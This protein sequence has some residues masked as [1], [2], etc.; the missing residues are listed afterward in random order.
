[1]RAL[2]ALSASAALYRELR[3]ESSRVTDPEEPYQQ[4]SDDDQPSEHLLH[5]LWQRQDLLHQPLMSLGRASITVYRPGRWSRSSGP[6]FLD[7]KLRFGDNAIRVGAVE[8]HVWASDW[9]RHRHDLDPA[10][11]RVLLHVVWHNDLGTP[12]VVDASG[13]EIPQLVLA[14][15]LTTPLAELQRLLDDERLPTGQGPAMT[16]CQQA[17]LEMT[18]E[19]VGRLLEMA[20]EERWR[21][22]ANRFALRVERRGVE[23]ALYETLMEALGYQGNRMPFWQ[24]AKLAPVARL[25]ET[26]ASVQPT[27]MRVQAILYGVSGFL[28][29]W[30]IEPRRPAPGC[31]AYVATLATHW[32][33]MASLFPETLDERQWRT[34]GIRPANFPQRRI[35]AAGY[36]LADLTQHSLMEAWFAPIRAIDDRASRAQLRRCTRELARHLC[37]TGDE[38]FWSRRY[39]IDGPEQRQP[40]DLLGPGRAT[41]MVV[42]VILPA[43]AALA[44]LGREP[45]ALDAVR[46]LYLCQPRLPVN[47]I[48]R[49]MLR[50]FFGADRARAAIVNSACRQQGLMQLYRDFCVNELETCQ[51]CAFPRLV[52]RLGRLQRDSSP[53]A[54]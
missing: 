6:D 28:Q 30:Q 2:D 38:D 26:L 11:T 5:L 25:R 10:Y 46:A 51:E 43:A 21:Q 20:G 37:V 49:E 15:A 7:A 45:I 32:E 14:S 12:T 8:V 1:M 17:M 44:Q 16:P 33:P 48:T 35:A 24:L 22:K 27:P 36:L 4:T 47:E 34:A 52:G 50:Q 29:R 54:P 42:D 3:D 23:Q 9:V 31:D 41:T 40:L 39:T 19:M 18:P 13:R 53:E